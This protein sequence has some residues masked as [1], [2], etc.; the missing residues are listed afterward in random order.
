MGD[1]EGVQGVVGGEGE[2]GFV[3]GR[4]VGGDYGEALGVGGFPQVWVGVPAP[5][6][7]EQLAVV[8]PVAVEVRRLDGEGE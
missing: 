6:G 2:V 7:D 4:G 8:G 1:A 3:W 5:D